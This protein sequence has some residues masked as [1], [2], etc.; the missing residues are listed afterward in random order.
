M[1]RTNSDPEIIPL[2]PDGVPGALGNGPE[3][4]P[5]LTTHIPPGARPRAGIIICP[6]GGYSHR[7]DHEGAPVAEWLCGLGIAGFVLAYR[8]SPY[9][10]PTPLQDAQR[11]VRLVRDQAS[12]WGIDPG[13]V[14]ILGFSAGGHCAAAAATIFD[15]GVPDAPDPV[16]RQSS[17]PDTLIACYPVITFGEHGHQGS[18]HNL[19]ADAQ[20]NVD[21]E[22]RTF[23]SLENRVTPQ[24]PP[25]FLWH[26][27]ADPGVSVTNSLLFADALRRCGVPFALHVFPSGRHGLGLAA[28]HPTVRHWT[29]ICAAW[30]RETGFA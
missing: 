25:T 1:T 21:P 17:R 8:V 18:M 15:P 27:A 19:L 11:A 13:R 16:E 5:T 14:G 22:L 10:H 7:A 24:T 4:T 26:T 28:E 9:R 29:E 12:D 20:G 6:G 3:D 30:L 2:W 23:M